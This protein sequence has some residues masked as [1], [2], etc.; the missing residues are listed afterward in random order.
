VEEQAGIK[1]AKVYPTLV[2]VVDHE[3]YYGKHTRAKIRGRAKKLAEDIA[4][5][6]WGDRKGK[7][8]ITKAMIDAQLSVPH[9]KLN[10]QLKLLK[11]AELHT[12]AERIFPYD[13]SLFFTGYG[14]RGEIHQQAI[15][16]CAGLTTLSM[17]ERLVEII[18][19]GVAVMGKDF[20]PSKLEEKKKAP[21]EKK[22]RAKPPVEDFDKEA[23]KLLRDLP[24][25]F[26]LKEEEDKDLPPPRSI[27][28]DV[29]HSSSPKREERKVPK[30]Q[31]ESRDQK[32]PG[33]NYA[34]VAAGASQAPVLGVNRRRS[35]SSTSSTSSD[36][37]EKEKPPNQKKKG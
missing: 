20:S 3:V 23:E 26:S 33:S 4:L 15:P 32:V 11:T 13:A 8:D 34:S 1:L 6:E 14:P 22:I 31:P 18:Q 9:R 28:R 36:K 24:D 29:E 37:G 21:D 27:P 17:K 35:G 10:V 2:A 12:E 7:P 30:G 25:E 16:G 19:S 5:A